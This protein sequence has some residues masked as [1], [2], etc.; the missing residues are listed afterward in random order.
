MY[1]GLESAVIKLKSP[2]FMY[3]TEDILLFINAG[4]SLIQNTSF[5]VDLSE[6]CYYDGG[7][8]LGTGEYIVDTKDCCLYQTARY[9]NCSYFIQNIASGNYLVDLH[10][11]EIIF[12]NG[13]PG[14]RTFDILVQNEKVSHSGCYSGF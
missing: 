1:V 14:L 5:G 10:F 4:G 3:A 6:D 7:D 9:G 2:Y 13:P 12:T 8:V 11:A